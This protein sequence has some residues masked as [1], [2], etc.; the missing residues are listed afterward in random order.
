MNSAKKFDEDDFYNEQV[1][2]FEGREREI[3]LSKTKSKHAE[4]M[5]KSIE[6]VEDESDAEARH[7]VL[8]ELARA[9]AL[10]LQEAENEIKVLAAQM[11]AEAL[12]A[13][14]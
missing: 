12:Q 13:E 3:R 5:R 1:R 7:A 2:H 10:E 8:E 6:E 11:A 4:L 9:R 14:K